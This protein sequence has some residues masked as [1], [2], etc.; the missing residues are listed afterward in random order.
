MYSYY[1]EGHVV[2]TH[3][4]AVAVFFEYCISRQVY[5]V[6]TMLRAWTG[7][8]Q[9]MLYDIEEY[10]KKHNIEATP[11]IVAQGLSCF[12]AEYEYDTET[13]SVR[14]NK[15]EEIWTKKNNVWTEYEFNYDESDRADNRLDNLLDRLVTFLKK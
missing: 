6:R 2:E 12:S 8:T 9:I 1:F 13:N 11:L 14:K 15:T 3:E 5:G 4:K 7:I 10:C